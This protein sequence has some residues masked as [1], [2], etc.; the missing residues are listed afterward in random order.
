MR[1]HVTWQ[2]A[3]LAAWARAYFQF[4]NAKQDV[5]H[6]HKI[7]GERERERE[8][9][10]LNSARHLLQLAQEKPFSTQNSLHISWR[11]SKAARLTMP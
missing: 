1:R 2:A 8:S 10:P 4:V 6:A 11:I 7:E 9:G 5:G 3:V